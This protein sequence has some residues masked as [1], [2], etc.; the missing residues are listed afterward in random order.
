MKPFDPADHPRG[1][2]GRFK[3]KTHAEPEGSLEADTLAS[4][5]SKSLQ[6][7]VTWRRPD[8]VLHRTDGPAVT[9]PDGTLEWWQHGKVHREDGPA[10]VHPDGTEAW[11]LNGDCH[12]LDGPSFTRSDGHQEWS[13]YGRLHRV[14]GPA[15]IRSDG[16]LEWWEDDVR[17]P[18]EMEAALTM[19]WKARTPKQHERLDRI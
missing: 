1:D 7:I 15:V 10:Y 18:P 4:I 12:R 6:G 13:V 5:P 19:V 2:G 9:W 3:A 8:G 16:T 11:Y 14:D 17:K